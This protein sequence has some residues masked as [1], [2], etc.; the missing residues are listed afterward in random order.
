M[1]LNTK[2][3]SRTLKYFNVIIHIQYMYVGRPQIYTVGQRM[4][5]ICDTDARIPDFY[6]WILLQLY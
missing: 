1:F 2:F 5:L 4:H 6:I 3:R